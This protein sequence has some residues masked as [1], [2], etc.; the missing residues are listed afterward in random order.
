LGRDAEGGKAIATYGA[1]P[2]MR[3]TALLNKKPTQQAAGN[4][5]QRD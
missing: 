2:T 5:T 4:S 3:F 1:A